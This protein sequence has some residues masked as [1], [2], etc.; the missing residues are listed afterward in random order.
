MM[1]FDT[2]AEAR[3][4][5]REM[6]IEATAAIGGDDVWE[7]EPTCAIA[8]GTADELV[9]LVEGE[10]TSSDEWRRLGTVSETLY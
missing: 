9:E 3:A 8:I 4:Y 6:S 1:T 2:L 5:V 10:G 7:H